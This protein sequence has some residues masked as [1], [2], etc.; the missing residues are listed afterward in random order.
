MDYS[1]TG[2]YYVLGHLKLITGLSER[3]LRNYI[4]MGLLNGEKINGMWH[5]TAEQLE[6]FFSNPMVRSA[7]RAKKNALIYDFLLD[8]KK[9]NEE[10]CII[11]DIPNGNSKEISEF[12]CYEI[13]NG[14]FRNIDFSFDANKNENKRVILKGG[15]DD[16]LFLVN[17]YKN[18]LP[19]ERA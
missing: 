4:S 11:L 12:F 1:A 16:V 3:T 10:C 19:V 5:F 13:S 17:K 14:A 2:N 9:K 7:I 6:D 8:R 18:Q 15:A